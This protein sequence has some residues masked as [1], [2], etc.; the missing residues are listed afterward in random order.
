MS[1]HKELAAGR[2]ALLWERYYANGGRITCAEV[3]KLTGKRRS[4]LYHS[5]Q[6]HGIEAP[7]VWDT[8][9]AIRDRHIS[10]LWRKFDEI[11]RDWLTVDEAAE[12]VGKPP[13]E[14]YTLRRRYAGRIPEIKNKTTRLRRADINPLQEDIDSRWHG[15]ID[16][17]Y[18]PTGLLVLE[19]W[20]G[21]HDGQTTY[22]L[23]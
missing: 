11:D 12:A 18:H 9:A 16:S 19:Y 21:P 5:F 8:K 14:I 22:L 13:A 17:R 10:A 7:T 1:H 2:A 23:R 15:K 3:L 4:N 6:V 20:P